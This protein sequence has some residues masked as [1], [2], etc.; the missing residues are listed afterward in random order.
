LSRAAGRVESEQGDL[1]FF[2]RDAAMKRQMLAWSGLA[3]YLWLSAVLLFWRDSEPSIDPLLVAQIKEGTTVAEIEVIAGRP[4]KEL[5]NFENVIAIPT[6]YQ[7][8]QSATAFRPG[9]IRIHGAV[10]R[11]DGSG[12]VIA[13]EDGLLAERDETFEETVRRWLGL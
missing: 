11:F 10:I 6:N 9:R 12:R 13:R 7:R 4:L 2:E 8:V 1:P 3:I 5:S